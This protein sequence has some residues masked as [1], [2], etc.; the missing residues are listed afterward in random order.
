MSRSPEEFKTGCLRY[1]EWNGFWKAHAN[2]SIMTGEEWD[3]GWESLCDWLSQRYLVQY[4]NEFPPQLWDRHCWVDGDYFKP[5]RTL[6]ITI[7]IAE[8]MSVSFL[9]YIQSWLQK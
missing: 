1:A 4:S 9:K 3:Q 5:E 6:Q 7:A 8:V 2:D